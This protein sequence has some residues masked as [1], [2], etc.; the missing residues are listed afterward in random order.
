[1]RVT[2]TGLL[3]LALALSGCGEGGEGGGDAYG[4]FDPAAGFVGCEDALT[5]TPGLEMVT[6]SGALTVRLVSAS[7]A[8]PDVGDN[9]WRF[10][11]LDAD[12]APAEGA[13]VEIEPFMPGHGH[14]T[15][16]RF[17]ASDEREGG[18]DMEPFNLFMPGYWEMRVTVVGAGPRESVLFDFCIEG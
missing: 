15:F 12:G 1:M 3:A 6:D 5:Y 17:S 8:P 7:P 4:G 14:G 11:V 2:T 16:P 13:F 10:E 9:L 18:Y